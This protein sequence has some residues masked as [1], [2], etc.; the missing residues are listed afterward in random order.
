MHETTRLMGTASMQQWGVLDPRHPTPLT[1]GAS[2][3]ATAVAVLAAAVYHV[4]EAARAMISRLFAVW[5]VRCR[6]VV[7][8]CLPGALVS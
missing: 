8:S 2:C 4:G 5:E 6:G 3:L 7:I 1:T